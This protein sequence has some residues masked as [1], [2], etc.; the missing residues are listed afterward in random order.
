MI[1][2]LETLVSHVPW[3]CDRSKTNTNLQL[4]TRFAFPAHVAP[5]EHTDFLRGVRRGAG[6]DPDDIPLD[7][8]IA[9]VDL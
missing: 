1:A 3:I 6:E 8:G 7:L 5:T 2:R 9:K 4:R